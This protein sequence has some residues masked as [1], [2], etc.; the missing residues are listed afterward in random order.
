MLLL[1]W[2]WVS[3]QGWDIWRGSFLTPT[4]SQGRPLPSEVILFL[5]SRSDEKSMPGLYVRAID[6]WQ[7]NWGQI[8]PARQILSIWW[9]VTFLLE[10]STILPIPYSQL[11]QSLFNIFLPCVSIYSPPPVHEIDRL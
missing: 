10:Y 3:D 5:L 7:A 1:I 9:V 11:R 2:S 6:C 8:Y 4:L